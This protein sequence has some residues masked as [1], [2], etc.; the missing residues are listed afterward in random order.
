MSCPSNISK[1]NDKAE[2]GMTLVELLV[3]MV[4]LS[5]LMTLVAQAVHQVAL[6]ARASQRASADLQSRW[7]GG[8]S[9]SAMLANLVAPPLTRGT[10]VMT[11]SP[12]Q[13]IGYS[14]LTLNQESTGLKPFELNLE[15]ETDDQLRAG[16]SAV[17][18]YRQPDAQGLFAERS[19]KQA[20]EPV[21]RFAEMVEFAY[22]NAK[23]EVLPNWPLSVATTVGSEVL[24]RSIL[25]RSVR[26]GRILM[27]Y[28]FA[29]ETQLSLP[30]AKPFW[31]Q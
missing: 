1:R 6:I 5:L 12:K 17:L 22:I 28:P 14:T 18:R 10:P 7:S 15:T 27:S 11:G 2:S 25:I 30:A 13:L 21:A 31:E 4:I 24:P 3:A 29:G 20:G 9:V 23:G 8:W 19:G 16:Q 26:N